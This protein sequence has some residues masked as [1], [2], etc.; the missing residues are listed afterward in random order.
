[1]SKRSHDDYHDDPSCDNCGKKIADANI[2]AFAGDN[3]NVAIIQNSSM[4]I[5]DSLLKVWSQGGACLWVVYPDKV[6]SPTRCEVVQYISNIYKDRSLR[7][8]GPLLLSGCQASGQATFD[9]TVLAMCVITDMVSNT[10]ALNVQHCNAKPQTPPVPPKVIWSEI[11]VARVV[12]PAWDLIKKHYEACQPNIQVN[13]QVTF[14]VGEPCEAL[15]SDAFKQLPNNDNPTNKLVTLECVF[16]NTGETLE[17][18]ACAE[19]RVDGVDDTDD[20]TIVGYKNCRP[21]QMA[22]FIWLVLSRAELTAPCRCRGVGVG[23]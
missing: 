5:K 16:S 17:L 3:R 20:T 14:P 12:Q 11:D 7:L 2:D 19:S 22:E 8:P 1:M 21:Y 13:I 6:R 23:V 4:T 10:W 15:F 18:A 9:N